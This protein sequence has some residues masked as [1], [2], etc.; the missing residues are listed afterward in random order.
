MNE[1]IETRG[2]RARIAMLG[3]HDATPKHLKAYERIHRAGGHDVVS[4]TTD[5]S[6]TLLSRGGFEHVGAQL[7]ARLVEAHAR[8]PRLLV[9]HAF[10]NAGFWTLAACLKS[11]EANCPDAFASH[12]G[13]IV[14]SAPGFPERIT[15]EF[16]ARTAPMAFLPGLLGRLGLP[17]SYRHPVASPL[18][19][20]FF[21]LWHLTAPRRIRAMERSSVIVREAHRPKP[22]RPARPIL[23]LWGGADELVA[24]EHVETF[25][26][27]CERDGIAVERLFFPRSGHVRHLVTERTRYERAVRTFV[28]RLID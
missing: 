2:A 16:T 12:R 28:A 8:E 11:L 4:I 22:A 26:A 13:T 9:F 25:L 1:R 24:P 27:R 18:L 23:A 5:A 17:A 21:G 15:V 3:W 6:R 19:G 20:V 7:A 10:S 14:D